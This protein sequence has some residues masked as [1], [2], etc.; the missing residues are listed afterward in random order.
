MIRTVPTTPSATKMKVCVVRNMSGRQIR[1]LATD[2]TRMI[3]P[4]CWPARIKLRLFHS[5]CLWVPYLQSDV[6]YGVKANPSVRDYKIKLGMDLLTNAGY[7]K[8]EP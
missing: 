8:I 4:T 1:Q 7:A 5:S 3:T 2:I 6:R